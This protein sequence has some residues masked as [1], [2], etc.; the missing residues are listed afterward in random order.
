MLTAILWPLLVLGGMGALFGA[1]L[2]IANKKLAVPADERVGRVREAL[3][4]ANCGGCGRP[5][6]DAFAAA[7][8]AGEASV[9]GCPVGGESVAAAVAAVMGVQAAPAQ[10][11]VAEVICR[12]MTNA[13]REKFVYKGLADCAAAALTAE[14]PRAGRYAC[15]GMGN[16]RRA[17]AFGAIEMKDGIAVIDKAKC[18]S[19][20][21]CVAACP[22]NVIRMV[23][24]ARPVLLRCRS[25]EK[26]KV[27][28][29]ACTAGC[30]GCGK[31]A[32]VCPSAA[33]EMK[34]SLPNFNYELC[35]GCLACA[36]ACPTGAITVHGPQEPPA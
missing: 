3:P 35:T 21:R 28:R 17:C 11:A 12:G 6:C 18:A 36:K 26:G 19:C 24:L 7:V 30:I 34:D 23:P 2:A 31:C 20:G 4:G 29:D 33:I 10:A 9:S 8:V 32:K 5:G 15:V 16:C 13:C 1:G 22:K 14:G 25:A 27:V